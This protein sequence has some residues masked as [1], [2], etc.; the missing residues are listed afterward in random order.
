MARN[1]GQSRSYLQFPS[2]LRQESTRPPLVQLAT[3][4]CLESTF[5]YAA[6][7]WF[8]LNAKYE[9]R[10]APSA[11]NLIALSRFLRD[12]DRFSSWDYCR[13]TGPWPRWKATRCSVCSRPVCPRFNDFVQ[14]IYDVHVWRLWQRYSWCTRR[15]VTQAYRSALRFMV[16]RWVAMRKGPTGIKYPAFPV[17]QKW[18]D[19]RANILYLSFSFFYIE[20]FSFSRE[21][22][23]IPYAIAYKLNWYQR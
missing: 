8:Y 22:C 1:A 11:G 13:D 21:K 10:K 14:L 19:Y 4:K 20:I 6:A 9:S 3:L 12:N 16:P 17:R 18:R 7:N 15:N 5:A 23:F 2:I